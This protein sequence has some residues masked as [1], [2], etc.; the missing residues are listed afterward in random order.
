MEEWVA[1]NLENRFPCNGKKKTGFPQCTN[2]EQLLS[3]IKLHDVNLVKD[4]YEIY[5]TR[6]PNSTNGLMDEKFQ[7]FKREMLESMR[8]LVQNG[9]ESAR[10]SSSIYPSLNT[11]TMLENTNPTT[12]SMGLQLET[13]TNLDTNSNVE[14]SQ[15]N[16]QIMKA[17][18]QVKIATCP[19]RTKY[20]TFETWMSKVAWWNQNNKERKLFEK[21]SAFQDAI[22]LDKSEDKEATTK[23]FD[24]IFEGIISMILM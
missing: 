14:E 19:I 6:S 2:S 5:K 11:I 9:L 20:T 8:E 23:V 3:H 24:T 18:H 12:A 13:N 10:N 4:V 1:A 22:R 7:E 21:I 16:V 17:V 15:E